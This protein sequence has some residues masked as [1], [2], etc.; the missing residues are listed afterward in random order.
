MNTRIVIFTCFIAMAAMAAAHEV[1]EE[2]SFTEATSFVESFLQQEK[3]SSSETACQKVAESSM[4]EV[5]DIC[6]SQ[7]A[8]LT[9]LAKGKKECC[10]KGKQGVCA[11]K[12]NIKSGKKKAKSAKTDVDNAKNTKVSFSPVKIKNMKKGKCA[13]MFQGSNYNQIKAKINK[14]VQKLSQ[15]NGAVKAFKKGLKDAKKDAK[16]AVKQCNQNGKS[17]YSKAISAAKKACMS[18]ANK[19][20]YTRA[21]HMVCVLQGK[22]FANCKVGKLPSIK[23]PKYRQA[24]CGALKCGPTKEEIAAKKKKEREDR[25]AREKKAREER[26]RRAEEKRLA[27]EKQ[28]RDDA[29]EKKSKQPKDCSRH[30]NAQCWRMKKLRSYT[31]W[32]MYKYMGL[33]GKGSYKGKACKIYG[34]DMNDI[35]CSCQYL[36]QKNKACKAFSVNRG[37]SGRGRGNCDLLKGSCSLKTQG[38]RGMT[39]G[40][41]RGVGSRI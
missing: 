12:K 2:A 24:S 14:K 27:R 25:Q 37:P 38:A 1:D 36:C 18:S 11:A 7:Q 28:R 26:Q 5:R 31:G 3:G 30:K 29:K 19:K 21:K 8:I 6:K 22:R 9:K 40:H 10:D 13:A 15:A 33:N 20:A 41:C 16:A 23:A 39:Y 34:Q 32:T 17:A 35:V 4:K